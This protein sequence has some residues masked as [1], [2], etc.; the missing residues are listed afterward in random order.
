MFSLTEVL[1]SREREKKKPVTERL[2]IAANNVKTETN[3]EDNSK[4]ELRTGKT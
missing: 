3:Y 1:F 4:H 2:F